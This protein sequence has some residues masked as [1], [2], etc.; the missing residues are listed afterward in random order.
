LASA[1]AVA[2]AVVVGCPYLARRIF[3]AIVKET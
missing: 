1:I 2:R 3:V